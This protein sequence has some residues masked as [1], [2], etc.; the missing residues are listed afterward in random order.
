MMHHDKASPKRPTAPV[1]VIT[2]CYGRNTHLYNLL[3]ALANSSTP[4]AEVIIVNDDADPKRLNEYAL[5]IVQ[6]PT[7]KD[8]N[9]KQARF[10]IGHNRNIGATHA[11][12][13]ALIFL[14][15]DCLVAA[16]SIAGLYSKL[17]AHPER[18]A[19]GTA[20]ISDAPAVSRRVSSAVSWDAK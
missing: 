20:Q 5:N 6:I 1:S 4:P 2:T 15:V 19:D 9:D 17:T 3:A 10:D 13:D 8:G 18:A 12:F 11:S 16:D 7:T 14:D